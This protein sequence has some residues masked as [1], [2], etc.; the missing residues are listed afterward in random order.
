METE[1]QYIECGQRFY[2][3]ECLWIK[4]ELTTNEGLSVY[5]VCI[6]SNDTFYKNGYIRCFYIDDMVELINED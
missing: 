2:S 5:S 1:Y 3:D 4:T 6:E